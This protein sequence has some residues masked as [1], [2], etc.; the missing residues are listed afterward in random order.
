M[1]FAVQFAIYS[2]FCVKVAWKW[3]KHVSPRSLNIHIYPKCHHF[4]ATLKKPVALANALHKH[5]SLVAEDIQ[6]SIR[7]SQENNFLTSY[8]QQVLI[9]F[10]YS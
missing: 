9:H 3:I 10:Y 2:D 1:T 7:Y 8:P 4:N 6:S 5:F